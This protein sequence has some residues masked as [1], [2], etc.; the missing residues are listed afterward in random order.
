[1]RKGT[2][3]KENSSAGVR[4]LEHNHFSEVCNV[5]VAHHCRK[6]LIE[7]ATSNSHFS[8]PNTGMSA[9]DSGL[10]RKCTRVNMCT[11]IYIL[12]GE[13]GR[14]CTN[15]RCGHQIYSNKDLLGSI[16]MA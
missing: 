13:Y 4:C 1:M 9:W 8:R 11:Y 5:F 10:S 15:S 16:I 6:S 2:I 3:W 14:E 12:E 7:V